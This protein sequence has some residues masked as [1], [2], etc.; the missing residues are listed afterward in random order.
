[1]NP[2]MD[3]TSNSPASS[4]SSAPLRVAEIA[5][6]KAILASYTQ[7]AWR[8]SRRQQSGVA[9]S[10]PASGDRHSCKAISRSLMLRTKSWR[11]PSF[12]SGLRIWRSLSF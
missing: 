7:Y 5:T 11:N 2:H 10:L 12:V 1:M 6:R 9:H 3:N 8:F 4:K